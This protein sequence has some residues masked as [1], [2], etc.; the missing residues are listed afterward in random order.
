MYSDCYQRYIRC[1]PQL[2]LDI[3]R[4]IAQMHTIKFQYDT[5]YM[6]NEPAA[7]H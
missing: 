6:F 7:D 3:P 4:K 1:P 5:P 2:F